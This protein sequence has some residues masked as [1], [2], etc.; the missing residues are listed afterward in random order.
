MRKGA[1]GLD[2]RKEA[3]RIDPNSSTG[4]K[5]LG[6]QEEEAGGELEEEGFGGFAPSLAAKLS[7]SWSLSP[8][9]PVTTPITC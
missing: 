9:H 3:G 6:K 8:T 4:R 1:S 5:L 2:K 7:R